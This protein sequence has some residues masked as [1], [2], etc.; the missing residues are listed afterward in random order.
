MLVATIGLLLFLEE[1][2]RLTQGTELAW[3]APVLNQ[4]FG[5]ARAGEFIVTTAPNS[6]G[7][8]ALAICVAAGLVSC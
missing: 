2:L 8:A 7:A 3:T 4:P 6:L 5:L 1:L